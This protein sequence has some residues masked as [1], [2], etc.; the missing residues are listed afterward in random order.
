MGKVFGALAVGA[1]LIAVPSAL[2]EAQ[3]PGSSIPYRNAVNNGVHGATESLS[4]NA[5]DVI[6]QAGPVATS[7]ADQLKANLAAIAPVAPATTA[8][9]TGPSL[10]TPVQSLPD[11][12]AQR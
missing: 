1:A 4:T 12:G 3:T 5:Q 6:L 2:M 8:P 9:A 11:P 7:L 10:P